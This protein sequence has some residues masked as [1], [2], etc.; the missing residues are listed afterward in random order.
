[1]Y[2]AQ[3]YTLL[4]TYLKGIYLTL[5][6]WRI[7]RDKEVWMTIEARKAARK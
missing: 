7:G 6:V 5:N 2:V 4:F 1:M 3:T